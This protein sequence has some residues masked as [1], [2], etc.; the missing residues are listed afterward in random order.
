V[1]F[2]DSPI[3]PLDGSAEISFGEAHGPRVQV[4]NRSAQ[5]VK[6][7]EMAWLVSDPSGRQFMAASLPASDA[8]LYLPAGKSARL[9]HDT[10][11]RFSRR[12]EPVS[13]QKMTGFVSQVEF[14]DGKVWIPTRQNLESAALLNVLGPSPEEQR[15]T[16]LYRRKGLAALVEELKKF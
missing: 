3:E 16:D 6:Y 13:I 5:T 15:L 10:E 4:R 11:L 7:V 1:N 8:E 2:P 9:L 12:G 14:A